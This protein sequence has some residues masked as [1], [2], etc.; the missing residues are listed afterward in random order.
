MTKIGRSNV[1]VISVVIGVLTVISAFCITAAIT[2]PPPGNG[3]AVFLTWVSGIAIG[4]Y[5]VSLMLTVSE[6]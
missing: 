2:I 5:I 6:K 1:I 4:L 3:S